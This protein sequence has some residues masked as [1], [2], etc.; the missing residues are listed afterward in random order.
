MEATAD[1]RRNAESIVDQN[2][3]E[4]LKDVVE[5]IV[6]LREKIAEAS[7]ARKDLFEKLS[8]DV[9][10]AKGEAEM[11]AAAWETAK[12]TTEEKRRHIAALCQGGEDD[13]RR[14]MPA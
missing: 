2:I 3:G 14:K 4:K 1:F 9:S 13:D 8:R 12:K 10:A 6:E 7:A 11:A 5:S